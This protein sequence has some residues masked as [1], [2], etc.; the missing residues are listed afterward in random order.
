[1]PEL[2]EIEAL[3][4]T[5]EARLHERSPSAVRVLQ[6]ALVK[7]F[8]PPVEALIGQPL[9]EVSRH[10]KHLLLNFGR[11]LTM[12]VHLGIGG[13]LLVVEGPS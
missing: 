5:I 13:R 10:G 1:M 6:F 3:R 11:D 8:D 12:A 2:P 9:D 7:T 4:Q